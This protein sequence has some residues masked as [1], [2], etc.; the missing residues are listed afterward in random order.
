[1]LENI[2]LIKEVHEQLSIKKAQSI[3]TESLEK[4]GISHI[5][6][7]RLNQCSS[8]EIFYVMFIRAMMSKNINIVI[9]TPFLL[10]SNL[11]DI[12]SIINNIEILNSDK[13]IFILDNSTNK[14]HYKGIS[15]LIVK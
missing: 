1:M 15:C 11:A 6:L 13:N 5:A 3:A 9:L 8:I 7:K 2:A 14:I 4:I 12:Q 10:I